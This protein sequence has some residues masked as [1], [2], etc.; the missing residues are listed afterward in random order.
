MVDTVFDHFM[1]PVFVNEPAEVRRRLLKSYSEV[2]AKVCIGE[3]QQIVTIPEYLYRE[4][5]D[6]VVK[7]LVELVEKKDL[8]MYKRDPARL[9]IHIERTATRLIQRI[10]DK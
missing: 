8:P 6:E 7:T 2:W 4:K 10:Q 5:Y 1:R 9:R 3:T